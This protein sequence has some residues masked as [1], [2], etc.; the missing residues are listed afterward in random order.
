MKKVLW[1]SVFVVLFLAALSACDSK[2]RE[3]AKPE[4]V[5][6][7]V[8]VKAPVLTRDEEMRL[9]KRVAEY[10]GEVKLAAKQNRQNLSTLQ[11][12]IAE[13]LR[14]PNVVNLDEAKSMWLESYVH[15][16][17]LTVPS[18]FTKAA[19]NVFAESSNIW[20]ALDPYPIAVGF[21]DE[22]GPYKNIGIVH[23]YTVEM[24][25]AA[26]RSQHAI[27]DE[28][29]A[30]LGYLPMAFLLWGDGKT[31]EER[32][33][34]FAAS[35]EEKPI[36]RRRK[37]LELNSVAIA[38]DAAV[39]QSWLDDTGPLDV[40]FYRLPVIAQ[41]ELIKQANAAMI[42]DNILLP[43]NDSD[44]ED[45]RPYQVWPA[46]FASQLKQLQKELDFLNAAGIKVIE[47][48]E[49][50]SSFGAEKESEK[51]TLYKALTS[52]QRA[53]FGSDLQE[54]LNAIRAKAQ[55]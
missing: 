14:E 45:W 28:S 51:K 23:D 52:E 34:D 21:V 10:W 32:V 3:E 17:A 47:P 48:S 20:L 29:E 6:Q 24:S 55:Q 44:R 38:K 36:M 33:A 7:Q 1:P 15:Y 46:V 2:T 16:Q 13:F 19:P 25:E 12:V 11:E 5:A 42:E 49:S 22:F 27:T 50:L 40:L 39:L 31:S 37:L 53:Q 30:V 18:R 26:I 8:S 41:V 4:A 43:L 9:K 35:S 54:I